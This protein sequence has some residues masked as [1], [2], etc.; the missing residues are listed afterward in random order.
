VVATS[1]PVCKSVVAC[2]NTMH[3]VDLSIADLLLAFVVA[4][5]A[6]ESSSWNSTGRQ[7]F[8]ALAGTVDASA[9]APIRNATTDYAFDA[10]SG[11]WFEGG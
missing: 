11:Y 7:T 4:R 2:A 10:V 3:G 6:A 9:M 5:R 8:P 1:L